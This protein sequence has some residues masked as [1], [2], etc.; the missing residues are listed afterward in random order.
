[1]PLPSVGLQCLSEIA[2]LCFQC[3]QS[4]IISHNAVGAC[5]GN[6]WWVAYETDNR[7]QDSPR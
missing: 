6:R 5:D 1:M 7:G 3:L 4:N 2:G